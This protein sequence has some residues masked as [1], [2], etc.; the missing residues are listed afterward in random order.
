MQVLFVV[1]LLAVVVQCC[2]GDDHKY[3]VQD[4]HKHK[5]KD[6]HKHK[7]PKAAKA[8][9]DWKNN[10]LSKEEMAKIKEDLAKFEKA[11]DSL[12][13]PPDESASPK[14]WANWFKK[15]MKEDEETAKKVKKVLESMPD[16]K[17]S[18][19][20]WEEWIAKRIK[21]EHLDESE[22]PKNEKE[23]AAVSMS[24]EKEKPKN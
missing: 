17:A 22:K 3:K 20:E 11:V 12:P 4:E 8:Y 19:K 7:D 5:Q 24:E 13:D 10:K 15:Q 23:V 14:E 16:E 9:E 1:V 6:A 21:E 18:P 2:L